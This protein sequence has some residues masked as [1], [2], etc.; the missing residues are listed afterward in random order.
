MAIEVR[1]VGPE[2]FDEIAPLLDTLP[3]GAMSKADW[4]WMLFEYPWAARAPCGW[5]LYADGRA[6]GFIGAVF[7]ARPMLGRM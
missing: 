4:R 1:S 3:G 5:A 7:S 6:V 2:A